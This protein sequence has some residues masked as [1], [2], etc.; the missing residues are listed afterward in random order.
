[1]CA[2]WGLGKET[3]GGGSSDA[4]QGTELFSRGFEKKKE[5]SF[6]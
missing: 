3:L 1:M 5:N 4:D 2:S 6:Q